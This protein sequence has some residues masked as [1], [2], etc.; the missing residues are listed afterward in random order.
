MA[1]AEIRRFKLLEEERNKF[2]Q[3]QEQLWEQLKEY[4][5]II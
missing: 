5:T 4:E 2:K 1:P 3:D